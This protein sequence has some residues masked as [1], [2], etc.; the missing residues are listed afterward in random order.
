MRTRARPKSRRRLLLVVLVPV[1]VL[2]RVC[3]AWWKARAG[4]Q[5]LRWTAPP[6]RAP[7]QPGGSPAPLE[8]GA[9]AGGAEVGTGEAQRKRKHSAR[10]AS[11]G[12]MRSRSASMHGSE[13][14]WGACLYGSA[15]SMFQVFGGTR[16][17]I[18]P[19]G[20]WPQ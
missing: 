15:R 2:L 3:S 9:E 8:V 13:L 17:H 11:G 12:L 5:P 7:H 1:P 14:G 20:W 19:S 4:V 10:R 6:R 16:G 18:T